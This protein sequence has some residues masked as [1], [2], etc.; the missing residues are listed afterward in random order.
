MRAQELTASV[1]EQKVC[2]PLPDLSVFFPTTVTKSSELPGSWV[3]WSGAVW[4]PHWPYL[5]G[6]VVQAETQWR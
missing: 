6:E 1:T 4:G 3:V 5:C 2:A